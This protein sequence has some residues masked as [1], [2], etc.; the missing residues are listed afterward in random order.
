[1]AWSP[2]QS[3]CQRC[4]GSKR[5]IGAVTSG[6]LGSVCIPSSGDTPASLGMIAQSLY[7]PFFFFR[8]SRYRP[9]DCICIAMYFLLQRK[10][11]CTGFRCPPDNS[12]CGAPG[13][14]PQNTPLTHW[15]SQV[16][17]SIWNPT[18]S[19]FYYKGATSAEILTSWHLP[20]P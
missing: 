2:E 14:L 5:L 16:M 9:Q 19:V 4:P 10:P 6:S 11:F 12:H 18:T 1:M 3:T 13:E 15:P 17:L 7:K 20:T 8:V